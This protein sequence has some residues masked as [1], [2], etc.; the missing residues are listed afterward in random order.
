VHLRHHPE[1]PAAVDHH[2][3]VE[4]PVGVPQ[5]RPGDDHRQQVGAGGDDR[6]QT[7]VDGVE[8]GVLAEQVVQRVPGERELG[9]HGHG[10]TGCRQ[11]AADVDHALGVAAGIGDEDIGGAR[12]NPGEAVRV[13]RVKRHAVILPDRRSALIMTPDASGPAP[14]EWAA[15][16]HGAR[17]AP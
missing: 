17:S 8:H 4:E 9:E 14:R 15:R 11:P 1:H 7:L 5:R 12:G 13:Q 10:D 16:R 6:V 3:G 2:G